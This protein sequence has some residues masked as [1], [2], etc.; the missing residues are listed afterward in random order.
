[1]CYSLCFFISSNS[2]PNLILRFL[3]QNS[4]L[5]EVGLIN[6]TP[7]VIRLEEDLDPDEYILKYGGDSFK[8]KI[9]NPESAIE[10]SMKLHRT[11][12]NLKDLNDI[13]KYIDESLKELVNTEDDILVELTL[14]KN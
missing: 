5:N 8:S 9:N 4:S 13:S 6:I 1:M 2:C 14:K 3:R 7:K 12:K 10:F 11:N